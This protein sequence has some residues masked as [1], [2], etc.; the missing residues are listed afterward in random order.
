MRRPDL[1]LGHGDSAEDRANPDPASFQ[2]LPGD[3]VHILNMG[4]R[5]Q[6][7]YD[8]AELFMDGLLR[9]NYVGQHPTVL[10]EYRCGGFITGGF[11]TE[12]RPEHIRQL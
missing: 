11:N 10:V 5:R 7:R 6:F 1:A 12:N 9:G 2:G 4:T 3:L 8:T